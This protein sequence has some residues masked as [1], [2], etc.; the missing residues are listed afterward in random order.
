[1]SKVDR[2]NPKRS[3]ASESTYSLMEFMRQFPDDAACLDFLVGKLYPNGIYCPKCEAVTRHHRETNRPSY[4]CQYCGH[5]EHPLVGTIFEN[6]A[7]SL[8]LWFYG[9]YLM[10]S[11][12]CGISAKQLE[13]EL[14]VT[15]KT[16]WRMFHKIRSLLE[17]GDPLLGGTVEADEAYVGGAAKW[18]N[19]GI[20][21]NKGRGPVGKTPVFGL[22]KRGEGDKGGTIVAKVVDDA[23]AKAIL[24]HVR[25]KVLPESVVY[26]DEAMIY[27]QLGNMGYE[28]DW[29]SHSNKVYVSGDVHT[30]TIDGFWTHMKRGVSGVY[31]G[32]SPKH[33]QSY[34]DEYVF[35]YNHGKD[36]QGMFNAFLG[37][38]EKTSPDL[39]S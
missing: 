15:Y 24:P 20:P 25:T 21:E 13:R 27:Q 37:Q 17:Q 6:S 2:N 30:N 10:A 26:T 39:P 8:R 38:I 12:R 36:P 11:T 31:R 19:R 3:T 22:A 34:L 9:I 7:T 5:H 14:G 33:L 28:H 23:G 32:V 18:R 16:A 4:A 35:R 1:M 29:V